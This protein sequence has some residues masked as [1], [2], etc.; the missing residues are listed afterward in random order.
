MA[1]RIVLTNLQ[2]EGVGGVHD[3][4]RAGPQP[5]EVDVE[6][7]LDLGPAGRDDDLA[8]TIDYGPVA[9]LV[10]AVIEERGYRL[11]EA[12]AEAIA[13]DV[14]AAYPSVDEVVVRVRKPAVQLAVPVDHAAV[15]VT[16]RR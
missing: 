15:E 12:F 9:R 1:D 11:I 8:R 10:K 13:R 16:R 6:L 4:E 5:W 2:L 14:L 3:W 7:V